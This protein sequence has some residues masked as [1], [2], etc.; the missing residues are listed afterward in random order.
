MIIIIIIIVRVAANTV[1]LQLVHWTVD[2]QCPDNA[3]GI[4]ALNSHSKPLMQ[5]RCWPW[6]VADFWKPASNVR[7]QFHGMLTPNA[8]W[9]DGDWNEVSART[10]V[11]ELLKFLQFCFCCC[12]TLL[13]AVS[14]HIRLCV[15]VGAGGVPSQ[16]TAPLP[17]NLVC[18][19]WSLVIATTE[20]VWLSIELQ[21]YRRR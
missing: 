19:I 15:C 6:F 8:G 14:L 9:L 11:Q 2:L 18:S 12:W 3:G 5:E 21:M 16:T 17:R 20:L 7:D 4:A 1:R 10:K 13:P